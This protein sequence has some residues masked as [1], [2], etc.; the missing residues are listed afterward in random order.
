M[1]LMLQF[2]SAA[3]TAVTH[4]SQDRG[5]FGHVCSYSN[6]RVF[7][8]VQTSLLNI[9]VFVLIRHGHRSPCLMLECSGKFFMF[10]GKT[11]RPSCECQAS[12]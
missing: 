5:M 1:R 2:I 12:F 3:V 4:I 11:I 8:C 7:I 10:N 6:V 9:L